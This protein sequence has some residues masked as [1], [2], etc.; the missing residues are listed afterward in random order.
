MASYSSPDGP[1]IQDTTGVNYDALGLSAA[2]LG[3][4]IERWRT[5]AEAEVALAVTEAT[6]DSSDLTERQV[7]V[8][9]EAVSWGTAARF[10]M[11][12]RSTKA[13]GTYEPLL[14][15]SSRE[16]GDLIDDFKTE[17][18][19][20]AKSVASGGGTLEQTAR[21]SFSATTDDYRKFT[22]GMDW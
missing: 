4:Q 21:I 8:L 14:T 20:L 22:R 12:V 6:F 1:T 17:M 16:I 7:A 13:D 9:Q 18:L 2:A 5:Q 11:R 10:L 19:S 3:R 15:E